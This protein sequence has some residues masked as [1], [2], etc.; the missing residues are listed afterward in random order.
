M[1]ELFPIR[2]IITLTIAFSL[3]FISCEKDD[4]FPDSP[5]EIEESAYISVQIS[6]E[7]AKIISSSITNVATQ[8]SI[9]NSVEISDQIGLIEGVISAKP[10][11]T[12]SGIYVQQT[13]GTFINLL[14]ATADNESLYKEES[15]KDLF[16]L[17]NKTS[18]ETNILPFGDKALILAPF[19]ESFNTDLTYLSQQLKAANYNVDI[20][21]NEEADMDHFRSS[22]LNDYDIVLIITHGCAN[23]R[24]NGGT[25]STLLMTGEEYSAGGLLALPKEERKA[26]GKISNGDGK[27]YFAISASWL[28]LTE[29]GEFKDSWIF[30][31]GCESSLVDE[32]SASVT[33]AFLSLGAEG[34]NGFDGSVSVK[35]ANQIIKKM[36]YLFSTGI[37]FKEATA[38][39]KS[40][41]ELLGYSSILR[42]SKPQYPDYVNHINVNLFDY[43][44]KS[45]NAFYID[46]PDAIDIDGNIYR[47]V[48]IG[49]QIWFAENLRVKRYNNGEPISES[50][51]IIEKLWPFINALK[52]I[53]EEGYGAYTLEGLRSLGVISSASKEQ[54]V[55]GCTVMGIQNPEQK[56]IQILYEE[57]IL[58]KSR[59][60]NYGILYSW[61]IVNDSRDLCP[62]G[63][64]IPALDEWDDLATSLGGAEIAGGKLKE[65]GTD[66]WLSPNTNATNETGFSA[67]PAGRLSTAGGYQFEGY[68]TFWWTSDEYDTNSSFSVGVQYN[69]SAII[70]GPDFKNS[71]ISVRCIKDN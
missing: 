14:I 71:L 1:M 56:S 31:Y 57:S 48:K 27:V 63:W 49:A 41:P 25:I 38:F 60:E 16:V 64:H 62:A 5:E 42:I 33:N 65:S 50:L 40:D 67:L 22:F 55:S 51:S 8:N 58:K 59:F 23:L 2:K 46:P 24:T 43:K 17:N 19:Q 13:D 10:T 53:T 70:N 69:T 35:L 20:F 36:V 18:I 44:Q 66:Y 3:L 68:N 4:N 7:G 15:P 54:L 45:N 21:I 47:T 30:V 11:T 12:G 9:I 26:I 34:Y 37:S 32:G 6:K 61:N 28:S 52:L 39:V 29:D